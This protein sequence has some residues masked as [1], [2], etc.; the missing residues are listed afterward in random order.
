MLSGIENVN[1]QVVT[2]PVS[3]RCQDGASILDDLNEDVNLSLDI[4]VAVEGAFSA[5]PE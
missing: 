4:W 2:F 3:L 5:H 1:V